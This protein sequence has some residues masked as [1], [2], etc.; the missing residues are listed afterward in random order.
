VRASA[1][2]V[3]TQSTEGPTQQV[4]A[5]RVAPAKKPTIAL[6]DDGAERRKWAAP[7]HDSYMTQIIGRPWRPIGM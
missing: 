7:L 3:D 6:P 1:Q 2:L 4:K 5:G